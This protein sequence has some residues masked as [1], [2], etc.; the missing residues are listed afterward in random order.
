VKRGTYIGSDEVLKG[1]TALVRFTPTQGV[2]LAQF[3]NLDLDGPRGWLSHDW[4]EF[5]VESFYF[6]EDD[7][8]SA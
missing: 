7:D 6:E 3:D 2:V 8:A 4:T 5:L 1:E